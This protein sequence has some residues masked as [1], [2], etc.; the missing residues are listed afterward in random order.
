MSSVIVW[1]I[2]T[3]HTLRAIFCLVNQTG[4]L[5]LIYIHIYQL[6]H[7][8]RLAHHKHL[9]QRTVKEDCNLTCSVA[10]GGGRQP[11]C[12]VKVVCVAACACECVLRGVTEAKTERALE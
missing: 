7:N 2:Y 3:I 10:G 9:K 1:A 8:Y 5:I 11:I 4:R 12:D 6:T